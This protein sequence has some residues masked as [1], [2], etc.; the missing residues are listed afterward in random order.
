MKFGIDGVQRRLTTTTTTTTTATMP[1]YTCP[2]CVAAR[3]DRLWS[4]RLRRPTV[5]RERSV[6]RHR[7][8]A[9][10]PVDDV[11]MI[12]ILVFY[13]AQSRLHPVVKVISVA[14][15]LPPRRNQSTTPTF[16]EHLTSDKA[17]YMGDTWGTQ[18]TSRSQLSATRPV[19][20]F[21]PP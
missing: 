17:N 7:R 10:H 1:P 16:G 9:S 21:G 13:I 20:V 11:F 14:S 12:A 5:A 19:D 2:Q 3:R 18:V 8:V 4:N 15:A 6:C